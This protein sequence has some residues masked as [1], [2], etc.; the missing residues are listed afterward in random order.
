MSSAP[1]AYAE[2]I[3]GLSLDVIFAYFNALLGPLSRATRSIPIVFVGASDPVGA[4]Y[5]ASLAHSGGNIMG[6][7]LYEPSLRA[8]GSAFSKRLRPESP[9]SHF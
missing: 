9:K 8:S 3:V 7:T 2:E 1:R 6:F 4:G 5:V